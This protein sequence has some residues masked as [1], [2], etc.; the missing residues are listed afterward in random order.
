M[1]LNAN[2]MWTI[3]LVRQEWS[4]WFAIKHACVL[5][6]TTLHRREIRWTDAGRLNWFVT[7][8]VASFLITGITFTAAIFHVVIVFVF[9]A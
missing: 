9:V 5:P 3:D 4:T 2:S 8:T 1:F 6:V 7:W